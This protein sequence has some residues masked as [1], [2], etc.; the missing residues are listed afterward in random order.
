MSG[1]IGH[2]RHGEANHFLNGRLRSYCN[3]YDVDTCRAYRRSRLF[4]ERSDTTSAD[5]GFACSGGR[6]GGRNS[7]KVGALVVPLRGMTV[8]APFAAP[9]AR[10]P[11]VGVLPNFQ[12]FGGH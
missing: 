9:N 3:T 6:F 5:R 7:K 1:V 2:G 8:L 10:M 4:V 11:V 12:G